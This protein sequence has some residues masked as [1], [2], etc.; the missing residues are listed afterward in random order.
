[1]ELK[2]FTEEQIIERKDMFM[3]R[4]DYLMRNISDYMETRDLAL[5]YRIS[6][7][8]KTVKDEIRDE[9]RYLSCNR[10]NISRISK[11]HM[12]YSK[13]M[14]DA[15]AYGLLVRSNGKID[16]KMHTAVEEAQYR[17]NKPF[18]M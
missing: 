16:Q 7:E 5:G 13:G 1:M 9:A 2:N 14:Q 8:Y 11:T 15:S 3:K 12:A 10:N 4:L 17:L 18:Y 6:E